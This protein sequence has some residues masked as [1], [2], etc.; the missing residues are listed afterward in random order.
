MRNFEELVRV[1]DRIKM[2][3]EIAPRGSHDGEMITKAA[4]YAAWS[5]IRAF[6][7]INRADQGFP[8]PPKPDRNAYRLDGSQQWQP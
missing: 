2:A 1:V 8:L 3:E 5:T 6:V 7:D 4:L